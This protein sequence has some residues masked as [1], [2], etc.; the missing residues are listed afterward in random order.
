MTQGRN[1]EAVRWNYTEQAHIALETGIWQR[2]GM[3][4]QR[5]Q[6][7]NRDPAVLSA[8]NRSVDNPHHSTSEL[9]VRETLHPVVSLLREM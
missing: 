7:V 5:K 6:K 8:L 3:S 9:G 1:I 4:E 2:T